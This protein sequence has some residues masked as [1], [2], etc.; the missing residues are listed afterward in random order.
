MENTLFCTPRDPAQLAWMQLAPTHFDS[1]NS[2]PNSSMT[3][4][5]S[6][7]GGLLWP[8]PLLQDRSSLAFAILTHSPLVLHNLLSCRFCGI[9][10]KSAALLPYNFN[11]KIVRAFWISHAAADASAQMFPAP[12]GAV[13]PHQ[14]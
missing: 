7:R 10:K 8:M 9:L 2:G 13:P 5:E 11:Q 3:T 6:R 12:S 14:P 1:E 4:M